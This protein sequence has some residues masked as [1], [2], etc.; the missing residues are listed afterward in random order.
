[1]VEEHPARTAAAKSRAAV[2]AHD[3]EAWLTLFTDDACVEDP[4]GVSPIDPEGKGILGKENLAR[5]WD[6]NIARNDI[7][8]E[9]HESFAAGDEVANRMTLTLRFPGGATGT[10]EG[11]FVYKVDE[12]GLLVSMRGFWELDAM[13]ATLAE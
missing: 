7:G 13:L 3:K 12:D 8:F 10:V 1:M 4:I 6:T 9:V 11:V 2:T 5:F